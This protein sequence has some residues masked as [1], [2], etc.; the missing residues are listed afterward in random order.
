M[1]KIRILQY[2]FFYGVLCFLLG[3]LFYRNIWVSIVFMAVGTP[4]CVY[5]QKRSYDAGQK[6]IFEEQFKDCILSLAASL[7]TGYSPENAWAEVQKE[8]VL[9]HGHNS[10]IV[11]EIETILHML[12]IRQPL[13]EILEEFGE[14][15]GIED[16]R[17][18]AN[19]FRIAKRGGGD[20]V[21]IISSTAKTISDKSDVQR[22]IQTIVS[23]KKLEQRIMI[24]MP[25]A[26][27]LYM[28]MANGGFLD[29]LYESV[30]GRVIMTGCFFV[31]A[32]AFFLGEKIVEI[33]I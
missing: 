9:L 27:L 11:R 19:V 20:L 8:M 32:S 22:E 30:I 17:S 14:R 29:V 23:S 31:Y 3:W 10:I 4:F 6:K 5:R 28:D 13:E 33:D 21:S 25:L 7:R 18:F 26:I 2:V 16:I 1:K 15:S 24:I 12:S